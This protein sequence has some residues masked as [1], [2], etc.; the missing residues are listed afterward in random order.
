LS[1][2]GSGGCGDLYGGI[3]WAGQLPGLGEEHISDHYIGE[4]DRKDVVRVGIKPGGGD[5]NGAT[6]IRALLQY[7]NYRT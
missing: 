6:P 4:V 1:N 3:G 2:D 5:K 7:R